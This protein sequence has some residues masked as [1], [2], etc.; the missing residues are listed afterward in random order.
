MP[1]RGGGRSVD[2]IAQGPDPRAI[3][4]DLGRVTLTFAAGASERAEAAIDLPPE[5]RNRI[6]RFVLEG[7][8]GRQARSAWPTTA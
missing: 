5:L 1:A 4:R 2:V 7:S 8:S 6:N 3:E